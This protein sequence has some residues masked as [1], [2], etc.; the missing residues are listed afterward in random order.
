MTDPVRSKV[1]DK[2]RA[3]FADDSSGVLARRCE[4]ALFNWCIVSCKKD[5]IAPYWENP[6]FRYRYTNKAQS[7][8]FN[9]TNQKNPDLESLRQNVMRGDWSF[10]KLCSATPS[11]IFP[12]LW[13]PIFEKVAEKQLRKQLTVDVDKMPD[14]AYECKACKSKKTG[15]YE[16]QTR[17]A[18]EP[19]TIYVQCFACQK[20][21]KG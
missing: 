13:Q 4:R 5:G 9:L 21:W 16:L 20:R 2:L 6:K 7:L 15:F 8:Q 12:E 3:V 11:E 1:I 17:S 19:M 18:D 10:E 14:G